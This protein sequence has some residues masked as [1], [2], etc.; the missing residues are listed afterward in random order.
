MQEV[1]KAKREA[2]GLTQKEAAKKMK[3]SQSAISMWETGAS[4]PKIGSLIQIAQTYK[5]AVQDLFAGGDTAA[6]EQENPKEAA[7]A[8]RG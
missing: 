3:I 1:L 5:C 6:D 2:A 8:D 4:V 7:E